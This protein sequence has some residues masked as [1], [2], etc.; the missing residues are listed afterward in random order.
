MGLAIGD[1]K[2]GGVAFGNVKLAGL[3]IGDQLL[4]SAEEALAF[5]FDSCVSLADWGGP[6][7]GYFSTDGTKM[8]KSIVDFHFAVYQNPTTTDDQ[9]AQIGFLAAGNV[10]WEHYLAVRV[11]SNN[12]QVSNNGPCYLIGISDNHVGS[13]VRIFRAN[14][15]SFALVAS[16][17]PATHMTAS[18]GVKVLNLDAS[19]VRLVVRQYDYIVGQFIDIGTF[20]D[21]HADRVMSGKFAAVGAYGVTNFVD[22]TLQDL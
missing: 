5:W 21:T 12:S 11:Q 20:D 18:I 19:T 17:S 6:E 8:T 14:G 16:F 9:S 13:Q 10:S 2:L 3:A 7:I 4:W 22:L 1:E 15:L